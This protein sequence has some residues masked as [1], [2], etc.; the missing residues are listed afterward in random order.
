MHSVHMRFVAAVTAASRDSPVT[1]PWTQVLASQMK[2]SS[3]VCCLIDKQRQFSKGCQE[4]THTHLMSPALAVTSGMA[5]SRLCRILRLHEPCCSFV[6]VAC[7][8]VM[9]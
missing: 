9:Q 4:Y 6:S 3:Y 8:K 5:N 7:S 1:I 2:S